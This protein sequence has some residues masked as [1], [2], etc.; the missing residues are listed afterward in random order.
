MARLEVE[1]VIVDPRAILHFL[2]L[3]DVLLLL[4]GTGGLGLLELVL[5][6]VHHLHDG[7]AGRGRHFHQIQLALRRELE[8]V[9]Q[10]DDPDLGS[11]RIDQA[12]R[13]DANHPVDPDALL[14]LFL[15]R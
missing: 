11:V 4:R 1:V 15:L 10:C 5:A 6:P 8:G 2:D 9:L 13:A 14:T 3:D 7:G 12:D